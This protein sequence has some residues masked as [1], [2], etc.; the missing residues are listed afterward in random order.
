MSHSG[1]LAA[2][3]RGAHTSLAKHIAYSRPT[4]AALSSN[5]LAAWM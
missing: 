4:A 3:I 1:A 2:H 5:K